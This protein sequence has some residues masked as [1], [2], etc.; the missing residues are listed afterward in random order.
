MWWNDI[1]GAKVIEAQKLSNNSPTQNQPWTPS[2]NLFLRPDTPVWKQQVAEQS[3]PFIT[4]Y[5]MCGPPHHWVRQ[6]QASATLHHTP[7]CS[8]YT[9]SGSFN[10]PFGILFNFPSQYFSS[11]GLPVIFRIRWNLPPDLDWNHNQPDSQR[12][13]DIENANTGQGT[14]TLSGVAFQQTFPLFTLHQT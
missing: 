10:F 13:G 2:Y 3:S 1:I 5:S 11:I 8:H 12:I 7:F 14:I 4:L 6:K 9:I